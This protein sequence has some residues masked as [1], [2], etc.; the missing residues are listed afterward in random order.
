MGESTAVAD[1]VLLDVDGTLVDSTYLHALAWTRAFG[2]HDL[3]P[4]WWRIHRTVG[5]GGDLLVGEVCGADVE[6]RLGD[7]LRSEWADRYRELLP[8]VRSFPGARE[9]VD[10]IRSAGLE[11]ALAS[12]GAAEFTDAALDILGMTRDDFD[13]VTSAEDVDR[14]KPHP[15]ILGTAL[16]SAGGTQALLVGDTVWDVESAARLSA[17]CV[18]VRTGGFSE[19]ELDSA[20]AAL[21]V[22]DIGVL[23]QCDWRRVSG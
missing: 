14:S 10:A 5:M 21:V 20:G 11:V 4:P 9:L 7:T 17:A 12:S 15:D 23:A 2:A 1:T 8:E 13:A 3:A 22:D 19:A 16:E 6:D 18:G